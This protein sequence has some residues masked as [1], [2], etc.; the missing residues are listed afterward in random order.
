[1]SHVQMCIQLSNTW[2][3]CT[4]VTWHRYTIE[5]DHNNMFDALLRYKWNRV[6]ARRLH[7][8]VDQWM[9]DL[10]AYIDGQTPFSSQLGFNCMEKKSHARSQK[11][12]IC[13]NVLCNR[14]DGRI[15]GV[16]C[17]H[18]TRTCLT[19]TE[20]AEQEQKETDR[21]RRLPSQRIQ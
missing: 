1:M 15:T 7:R 9:S 8:Y 16:T 10:P 13:I 3:R 17:A 5:S 12:T 4:V 20:F 6:D 11:V 14:S 18:I 2:Y 21:Q 19:D